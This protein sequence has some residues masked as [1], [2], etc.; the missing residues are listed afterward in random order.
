MVVMQMLKIKILY[1]SIKDNKLNH[2]VSILNIN[3]KNG[4]LK[5]EVKNQNWIENE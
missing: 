1:Y 2:P 3:A 5:N 4:S